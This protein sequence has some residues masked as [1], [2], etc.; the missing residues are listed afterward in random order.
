MLGQVDEVPKESR[1]KV[2]VYN[3]DDVIS[4]ARLRDRLEERRAE[5]VDLGHEVARPE[6]GKEPSEELQAERT[7]AMEAIDALRSNLPE[8][9]TDRNREERAKALLAD[10]I[11][12][13]RREDK[14]VY[15]EQY[16]LRAME[17]DE[18]E[19][20]AKG[21]AGLDFVGE[22]PGGTATRPIHRY[23]SPPQELDVRG[24]NDFYAQ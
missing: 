6:P 23:R 10:L 22:Q 21:I 2:L 15:W 13:E 24:K 12:F 3:K 1:Q 7:A 11:D 14:V 8:D 20:S 17:A 9:E 16:A 5:L 19:N 18:L 4:T